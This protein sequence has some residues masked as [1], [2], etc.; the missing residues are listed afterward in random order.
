MHSQ[1]YLVSYVPTVFC[2][3]QQGFLRHKLT[4]NIECEVFT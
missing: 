1:P 3:F 2:E 4:Y